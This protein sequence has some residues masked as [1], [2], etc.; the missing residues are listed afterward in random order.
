[1]HVQGEK[2]RKAVRWISDILQTSEKTQLE[3][4]IHQ[5]INRFDLN[6][7]ESEELIQFYKRAKENQRPS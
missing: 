3:T 7:R 4:L 1:M 5:A 2:T 6:P